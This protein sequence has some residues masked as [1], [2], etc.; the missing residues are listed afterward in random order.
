MQPKSPCDSPAGA[1]CRQR[2]RRT[3]VALQGLAQRLDA[4]VPQVVALDV[5]LLRGEGRNKAGGLSA[6]QLAAEAAAAGR[7]H[8]SHRRHPFFTHLQR[9]VLLQRGGQ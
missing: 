1:P 8:A 9:V 7:E 3:L 5:Q 4:L 6:V 2:R